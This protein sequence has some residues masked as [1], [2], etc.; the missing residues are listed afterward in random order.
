M[1]I[2]R[3]HKDIP[4]LTTAALP[5]LIFTVLFFFMIVTHLRENDVQVEYHH[6]QGTHLKAV[7]RSDNTIYIYIGH[8]NGSDANTIQVNK[9]V[10]EPHMLASVIANEVAIAT[11]GDRQ[12][13]ITAIISADKDTEMAVIMNVKQKLKSNGVQKIHYTATEVSSLQHP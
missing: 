8:K 4:S 11:Q 12:R 10:A 7:E 5:D 1:R 9:T 3:R 6:P 13:P 2:N